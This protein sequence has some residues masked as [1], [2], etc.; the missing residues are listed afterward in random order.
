MQ[1]SSPPGAAR[2]VVF[3]LFSAQAAAPQLALKVMRDPI[4]DAEL[5]KEFEILRALWRRPALQVVAPRPVGLFRVDR[6]LALLE[7]ALPGAPLN[8]LLR[9]RRPPTRAARH[10][11]M[12][13][14]VQ[15]AVNWLD[16]FQNTGPTTLAPFPGREAL[17]PYFERL[18]AAGAL[19]GDLPRPF[20]SGLTRQAD[21][22]QGIALPQVNAHGDYWPGNLLW[23]ESDNL[24]GVNDWETFQPALLPTHDLFHFLVTFAQS[25]PWEGGDR[26]QRFQRGFLDNGELAQLLSQTVLDFFARRSLPPASAP[27]LFALFLLQMAVPGPGDGR[28]RHEQAGP[29]Q[30]LL[31]DYARE[32]ARDQAD[33]VPGLSLPYLESAI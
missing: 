29:W 15:T 5:E 8:M 16:C 23:D 30:A 21:R 1:S 22:F 28:K 25:C 14:Y 6:Q 32:F 4:H 26:A 27:L 3:L 19:P 12:R 31:R 11:R 2:K 7:S 17:E 10:R 9:R 20:L 13:H 18:S 24:C 33:P